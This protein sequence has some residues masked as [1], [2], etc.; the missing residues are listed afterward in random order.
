MSTRKRGPAADTGHHCP[1]ICQ[2]PTEDAEWHGVAGLQNSSRS[3]KS[4]QILL[5]NVNYQRDPWQTLAAAVPLHLSIADSGHSG[6][7]VTASYR[8]GVIPS[9]RH[10]VDHA[11]P[12]PAHQG[13]VN[14]GRLVV[15]RLTS[16]CYRH[17]HC[18]IFD[19]PRLLAYSTVLQK[20][21]SDKYIRN[22][23]GREGGQR[24]LCYKTLQYEWHYSM[25]DT[26]VL[27]T[28]VNTCNCLQEITSLFLVSPGNSVQFPW[29]PRY[30]HRAEWRQADSREDVRE[31]WRNSDVTWPHGGEHGVWGKQPVSDKD[32]FCCRY[33]C[34]VRSAVYSHTKASIWKQAVLRCTV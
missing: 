11:A 27:I 24:P 30:R 21:S 14:K 25:N 10:T 2:S 7:R 32:S 13:N 12:S 31:L 17:W 9:R 29:Q 23:I 33:G 34:K 1:V 8:H 26:T 5:S 18:V 19:G 28:S 15:S 4:E 22:N 16:P 20:K 3:Y 6:Q